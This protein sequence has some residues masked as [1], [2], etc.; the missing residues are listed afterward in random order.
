[1]DSDGKTTRVGG[2]ARGRRES[3]SGLLAVGV[4]VEAE[5][6]DHGL[7]EQPTTGVVAR[8][9]DRMRAAASIAALRKAE[10]VPAVATPS[11]SDRVDPNVAYGRL[12]P[13]EKTGLS[14]CRRC[15]AEPDVADDGGVIH[16]SHLRHRSPWER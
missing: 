14:V 2:A 5:G 13:A 1:M 11:N 6:A 16:E 3:R 7:L 4:A 8:A 12:D 9:N 15:R 10:Y